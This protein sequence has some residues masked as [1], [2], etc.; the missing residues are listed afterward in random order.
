MKAVQEILKIRSVF[1]EKVN[2]V[3]KTVTLLQIG[4]EERKHSEVFT[5][6]KSY[7]DERLEQKSKELET[8]QKADL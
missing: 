2:L 8:K 3:V 1:R 5:L 6:F 7:L 4:F